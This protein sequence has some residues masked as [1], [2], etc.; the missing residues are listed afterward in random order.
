MKS[1]QW[2]SRQDTVKVLYPVINEWLVVSALMIY[3]FFG[4]FSISCASTILLISFF[5]LQS[6]VFIIILLLNS[7][8]KIIIQE[9]YDAGNTW[10]YIVLIWHISFNSKSNILMG[11]LLIFCFYAQTYNIRIF[12]FAVTQFQTRL[13][14]DGLFLKQLT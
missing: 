11:Q 5:Q 4:S 10:G 6:I 9:G 14:P 2:N 7:V 8:N 13:V 12:Y 1:I 3:L